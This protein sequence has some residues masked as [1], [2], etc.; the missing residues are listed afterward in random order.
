MRLHG[1]VLSSA[2]GLLY[3]TFA[4]FAGKVATVSK[5]HA[6]EKNQWHGGQTTRIQQ[7]I[8]AKLTGDLR[9]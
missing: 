4:A 1:V 2:Q 3:L 7:F 8:S 5:Q 9:V 6:M